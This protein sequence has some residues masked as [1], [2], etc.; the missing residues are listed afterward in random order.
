MGAN[1]GG[2]SY[3]VD[4]QAFITAASIT[5]TTQKSAINTLVLNLKTNS[6]WSKFKAIYPFVGGTAAQHRFNLKDPRAVAG[7]FYLDFVNGWTHSSNGCLPN[8]TDG[9]ANTNF[10]PIDNGLSTASAH[11]SYYART[12]STT[13]DG[14]EIGYYN[15]TSITG[16]TLQGKSST[17][18]HRYFYDFFKKATRTVASA[19]TGLTMGS[20]VSSIRRDLYLNGSTVANST[21]TDLSTLNNWNLYIGGA[22]VD[23]TSVGSYSNSQLAMVT[24]GS[25]LTSAEASTFY[26]AVQ[27]YQTSLGRQV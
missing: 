12:G 3:D 18:E 24:I 26:T 7:A 9:Y 14:A 20:S 5:N 23:N 2:S 10:K 15:S 1:G 8:G 22:N 17:L 19:P 25:G 4:A 27:A 11:I 13:S 21:S 16:F 6:I